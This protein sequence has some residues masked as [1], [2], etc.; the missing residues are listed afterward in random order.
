MIHALDEGSCFH[1]GR[2]A[3]SKH[4]A[5]ATKLLHDFWCSWAG[6]PK[7]IYL[8]PAGEFRSEDLLG[9]LQ[10]HNVKLFT[11]TSAW[12]RGRI[13][14]HGGVLKH[15]LERL[16]LERAITTQE[17]FD[18]ALL[19]CFQATMVTPRSKLCWDVP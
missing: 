8:D 19:Q 4:S 15:M 17:S 1:L 12:Q 7:E 10:G 9:H 16:D 13:E 14:R 6:M 3:V 18:E 5:V 11:T 2:R